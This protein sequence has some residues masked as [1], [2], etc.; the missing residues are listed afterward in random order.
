[1]SEPSRGQI[2][3]GQRFGAPIVGHGFRENRAHDADAF[4]LVKGISGARRPVF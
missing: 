3:D 4:D 1:M 2:G